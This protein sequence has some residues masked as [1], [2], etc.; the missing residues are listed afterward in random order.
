VADPSAIRAALAAVLGRVTGIRT[1]PDFQSQVVPPIAVVMPQR[2]QILKFDT[3]GGG[4]S[5]LL[6]AQ[7]LVAFNVDSAGQAALDAFLSTEGASSIDAAVR[8]DPT[9][10]GAADSC[11]LDMVGG[12]GPIEWAGQTYLG[13]QAMFTVMAAGSQ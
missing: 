7:L 11:N 2:R 5:Y 4:V 13:A 10:G 1:V 6:Y 8:A 12:Y 9:L 3:L